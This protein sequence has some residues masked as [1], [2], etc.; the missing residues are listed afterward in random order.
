MNRNEDDYLFGS[1]LSDS[2]RFSELLERLSE[3]HSPEEVRRI[4]REDEKV[5]SLA[6]PALLAIFERFDH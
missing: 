3:I 5:R 4:I 6:P 1:P 2:I